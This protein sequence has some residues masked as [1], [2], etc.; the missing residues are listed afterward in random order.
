MRHVQFGIWTGLLVILGLSVLVTGLVSRFI[1]R[2]VKEVVETIKDIAQGEGDLTKRLPI[3]G[4]N[5]IG[6]LSE[7][8][9]TFVHK[10]HGII[11]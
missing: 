1:T 7:W 10:L 8:F 11:S 9:N 6:E 4:N 5:E 3:S 2:P